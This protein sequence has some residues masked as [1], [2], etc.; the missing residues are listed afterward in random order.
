MMT[1]KLKL[2]MIV[3]FINPLHLKKTHPQVLW[4]QR[5]LI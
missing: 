2:M 1:L 4:L 3:S 5:K